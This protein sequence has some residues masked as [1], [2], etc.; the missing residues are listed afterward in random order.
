MS[1]EEMLKEMNDK[2]IKSMTVADLGYSVLQPQYF[3]QFVRE[4]T[5]DQIILNEARRIIMAAQVTNIDRVGFGDRLMEAAVEATAP[6]GAEADFAQVQLV[7]K[8]FIGM[9]GISD[10]A[11]RRNIE[12]E[13]FA[14]TLISLMTAKYGEDW[15]ALA[16]FGDTTKFTTTGGLLKN[17]DGWIKKATNKLYG[18]G[19]GKDYDAS[20]ADVSDILNAMLA[21]Y[22]TAYLKNRTQLRFYLDSEM[23]NTYIDEVGIRPTVTGDEATGKFIARPFKGVPVVEAPVLN[24][25]EGANTTDGWGQVAMLQNPNNMVYGIF[26]NITIEPDRNPKTRTT[27]YVLTTETDQAYENPGVAVIACNDL[28]KPAA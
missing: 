9:S 25:S 18:T 2:A 22:P 12:T 24:D 1:N 26:H 21:K 5:N 16:V 8:E 20:N 3:N 28:E 23:F 6:T 7:A 11:L 27:D 15:E 13:S 10:S 17:Q 4:A 14:S 19:T